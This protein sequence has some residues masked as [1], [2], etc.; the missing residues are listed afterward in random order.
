MP[1][2]QKKRPL[3]AAEAVPSPKPAAA[4][5]LS[6]WTIGV[7]CAFYSQKG[8][9]LELVYWKSFLLELLPAVPAI[10]AAGLGRDL[11]RAGLIWALFI[12]LGALLMNRLKPAGLSRPERLLLS[13]GLGAGIASLALLGLGL[14][15]L[16]RPQFLRAACYAG[17]AV[18]LVLAVME[19]RR[20]GPQEPPVPAA[21]AGHRPG[22]L[23]GAAVVLILLAA[24]M[25]ILATAAPETFYDSLVYHLALPKLYLLRG[26]VMPVPENLFSGF[27]AG[28]EMLYGLAL[29]LSNESLAALLHCS[30]GLLTAL[31]VG[32]L[33]ERCA[34]RAAA[35]LGA[36]LFY[37][38]PIVLYGSWQSGNDL[39][40]SCYLI[41]ALAA[42]ASCGPGAA[43]GTLTGLFLGL[44]MGVKYTFV[45]M[46]GAFVLIAFWLRRRYGDP[47]AL[48]EASRIAVV[49]AA[50]FCPW[51]LKNIL[52]YGNPVHPFLNEYLGWTALADWKGF[53]ADVHP[54]SLAHTFGSWA[55]WR[56]L[57]S[58]PWTVSLG[59]RDLGDWPGRCFLLFLP[60]AFCLR[61]GILKPDERI[62]PAWTALA[63]LTA[64]GGIIWCLTSDTV[65][66]YLATALPFA[67]C[68]A[69]LAV[70]RAPI[71]P[72]LR[73][74]GWVVAILCSMYG[75]QVT[76]KLGTDNFSGRWS[77]ILG[78][79]SRSDYLKA[80]RMS[81]GGIPYYAAMEYINQTLPPD[82]KVLFL[83]E[84]RSY[85][86][87]RDHIAATVFDHNPFW[88]AARAARTPA[89]LAASLQAMGVTHIFVGVAALFRYSGRAAV[90]PRDIVDG[91]LF[92]DFWGRY[93]D[94]L[95]EYHNETQGDPKSTWL[96]VYRL[97]AAP[98]QDPRAFPENTPRRALELV[99][100]AG[101]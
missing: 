76:F 17:A 92:G 85:Y 24:I 19:S 28:V 78:A 50:V 13:A 36:L 96:A 25:N 90:L 81:Y 12:S 6:L 27:P 70:V 61:W 75:L 23:P 64:A 45:P 38:S 2:K 79:R 54:H 7:L 34:S 3:P 80:D 95:F 72:R 83:G 68:V 14:A 56:G 40:G 89:E 84:P 63:L 37:L 30:F 52:F 46:A 15:G 97:R 58:L 41:L 21:A 42:F 74:A 4:L 43:R 18:G 91:K 5:L 32:L 22:L 60:W 100:S 16:W 101:F 49:S 66:R 26:R 65:A 59:S 73:Q 98:N 51:L 44:A 71:P 69:A 9:P 1:V 77:Q 62:P 67:A 8:L 20:G 57:L 39:A 47:G 99:R 31:A 87:E 82:A 29:A 10:L 86:C 88:R 53:M 93:L 35:I 11:L 33:L 94:K 48:K 55:G